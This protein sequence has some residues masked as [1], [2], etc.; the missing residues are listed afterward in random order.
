MNTLKKLQTRSADAIA[1]VMNLIEDLK[2]ANQIIDSEKSV[3]DTRIE[4]IKNT[5]QELNSL[6]ASNEKIISNFEGLLK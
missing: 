4:T 5:Q 2:A 6:R 3:N 1:T